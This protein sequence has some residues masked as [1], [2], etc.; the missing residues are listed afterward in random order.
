MRFI[1]RFRPSPAMA[2]AGIA[3]L[4]ALGGTGVAAIQL[5]APNS[6]GSAAVIDGSL[7]KNDF[8]AGI[9][10]PG[11]AGK[12]GKPG[13]AGPA[14]PAG[15]PG[16][17]GDAGPK[18]DQGPKGDPPTRLWA[19]V[20]ANG[21]VIIQGGGLLTVDS[22]GTGFWNIKYNRPIDQCAPFVS[23]EVASWATASVYNSPNDQ[24]LVKTYDINTKFGVPIAFSIVLYC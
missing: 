1:A 4:V 8:K 15:E 13:P 10:V 22:A 20:A 7:Q 11:K 24:I 23:T 2:V 5:A 17:K 21:Q 14:G 6:V 19:R 16:P 9:I 3:L 18:G 12:N